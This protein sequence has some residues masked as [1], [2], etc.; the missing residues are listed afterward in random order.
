MA[1]S[2]TGRH[3]IASATSDNQKCQ[4]YFILHCIHFYKQNTWR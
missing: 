3:L 2:Q 1:T 4:L